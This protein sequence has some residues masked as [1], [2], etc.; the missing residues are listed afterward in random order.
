M[1][2]RHILIGTIW[3]GQIFSAPLMAQQVN[4]EVKDT[5]HTIHIPEVDIYGHRHWANDTV[6]Y[7]YNQMRYYVST[8]LPYV[9]AAAQF[10]NDM[11]KAE[12]ENN[13]R[14]RERK[15]LINTHE[16]ELKNKFEDSLYTLNVTQGKLLIKLISRQ[17]GK[18]VYT[19][20]N[21]YKNTW[22]AV[23]WRL[24]GTVNGIAL[25]SIYRP[26]E[27]KDLEEIMVGFD[28]PLP[29]FYKK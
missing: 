10:Y 20:L 6:R 21:E 19:L 26:E 15:A 18:T 11:A 22:V 25:N 5:T 28:R 27:E 1:S 13:L 7:R 12:Q 24:W 29:D 23:K 3:F 4:I 14:R 9:D 17:T 16:A 2:L 8:I